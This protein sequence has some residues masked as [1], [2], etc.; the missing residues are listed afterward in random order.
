MTEGATADEELR[1][2][3]ETTVTERLGGSDE[4]AVESAAVDRLTVSLP[5]RRLIV[6]RRDGPGGVDHWTLELAADGATVSKFGPFETPDGLTERVGTL[7][8]SEVR[9][10]VCCDG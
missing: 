6:Q 1:A 8:E 4:W 3:L 7:L 2:R 10:T 9:Y 5:D